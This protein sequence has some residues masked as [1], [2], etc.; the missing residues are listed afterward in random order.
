LQTSIR[1]DPGPH[2]LVVE[3][4]GRPPFAEKLTIE[5]GK[6]VAVEAKLVSVVAVT[7]S[8][9]QASPAVMPPAAPPA[10]PPPTEAELAA[11][12]RSVMRTI[13]WTTGAAG[14]AALGFGLAER[15]IANGKFD[16]FNSR[17]QGCDADDRVLAHGGGDCSSLLSAGR[18]SATLSTIGFIA[19]GVLA[20][21]SAVLFYTSH[22]SAETP[23]L[24]LACGPDVGRYGVLCD[25]RF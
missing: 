23:V 9:P 5:G 17:P 14:V 20:G 12:R 25:L 7:V 16:D 21:A 11:H 2:Q 18:S 15:L 13:A 8:P 10:P 19:G 6:R 1:L 24:G 4:E 3:K 22:A